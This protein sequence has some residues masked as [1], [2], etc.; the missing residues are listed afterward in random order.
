MARLTVAELEAR[1]RVE[2]PVSD[3]PKIKVGM[4]TCGKAAGAEPVFVALEADL[5][6]RSLDWRVAR[7]GCAGMCSMEPL[8][9]VTLP[10]QAA[11][12]FGE[13]T[14]EFARR[15]VAACADGA[16]L[17]TENRVPSIADLARIAGEPLATEGGPKQYRIV[18]R[19]CGV[20]DPDEIDEYLDRG[21]YQAL[22][23]VLS[24]MTPEQVI[25]ELKVSG[26]RGRGG[27][28]FPAWLKWN[29]TRESKGEEHLIVCN[30]DEGD[31]GAYMDRSV[32]EGDP[33]A[34]L[35]G[36]IIGGY[37]IGARNGF[38]YIR[39]EYPLAIQRIEKALRQ[40]RAAGL[41][42]NNILGT[43]FS[44]NVE[45]RLGAGAFV[46]GEETALI[47]SV[48][49]KRGTPSPRPPY[50]SVKGLWG[51]PT[52]INN[53]ESLANMSQIL[54]RG[55]EWFAGI[56]MGKSTGTKVFA[57]T[58]KVKHAGLVE[59][60]MGMTLRD[61]VEGICGGSATGSPIKAV[62]TGG[63]SGGLIPA[64]E[65]DT[66]ITYEHL[67][68]LGSYMGSGGMI[69]MD[70]TDDLVELSRFYLGFC[71]DESC[72]KCAP[73]RIGGTQMLRLLDRIAAGKGSEADIA[74]IRRLAH[75]MQKASLCGL[76]Q[77][78]PNPV[79][80]ALRYFEPEFRGRLTSARN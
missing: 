55:G 2:A 19:N 68:K 30:G 70:E 61:V 8:V 29:L 67:Q 43:D 51:Q 7:T 74:T 63:P 3:R 72:G 46:C 34:V 6:E 62:Q 76:G 5:R 73:C 32:L 42:G 65:L 31:P 23:K 1:G 69:V 11:V 24:T 27:A 44:F 78:A 60:P 53:V 36:M 39:A 58:G 47:A 80:S 57:V 22:A 16:S 48:E 13:V 66:P 64:R 56:G 52:M 49:G 4:S 37:V 54:L 41:L 50:P 10:G 79:L 28:G 77:G 20:I 9:E 18:M 38:F 21:G 75:A 25:E 26:V 35:E 59:I 17:P 33:H 12:M 71:V 45:I 15:I 40:A 14:P